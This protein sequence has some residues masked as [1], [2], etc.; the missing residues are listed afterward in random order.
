MKSVLWYIVFLLSVISQDL[1]SQIPRGGKPFPYYN[2]KSAQNKIFLPEFDL[3]QAIAE[4]L[5]ENAIEGKKPFPFAWNYSLDLTPANSGTWSEMPDGSTIWRI[6][7]VSSGAFGVNVDFSKFQLNPGCMVFIY[8]PSQ[9]Y[10]FG[11]FNSGNN[12][13]SANLPVS[14][15]KGEEIVVELQVQKDI[16]FGVL[17]IGSLAHAYIDIFSSLDTKLGPSGNCN[18]DINCPDGEDWQIIKKAICRITIKSGLNSVYCTGTLINNVKQDTVPYLLTANHCINS[19]TKANSALFLFDYEADTCDKTSETG[20]FSLAG[21]DLLATSDSLDFTLLRLYD[22]IP[23]IYKPYFAGWSLSQTPASSAVTIHHPEG[24]LKK[25]SIDN[26]PVTAEYQD[27]IPDNLKWLYTES[28][29]KAFWR[30]TKWESGTTEGGSSGAPLFNQ[31]KMIVG[32][33]T[34]GQANCTN[35]INDYFS[36]FHM[37]WD[38][39]SMPSKQLKYWLN[40]EDSLITSLQ[41]FNPYSSD[42]LIID[43]VEFADRYT[44]FPNPTNGLFTFETDSLDISGGLL[45]IYSLTGKKIFQYE[46]SGEKRIIADVSFLEQGLYIVEFSKGF[47]KVR[48]RLL[49][50]NP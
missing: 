19:N 4:S 9:E 22:S 49:I 50:T 14:F 35:P 44:L 48:K 41:G 36:K 20:S 2:L 43:P 37:C 28:V 6:H 39:Y 17:N 47:E 46:I 27:P 3:N 21:S 1:Y 10:F 5:S 30:V 38:Y 16:D 34:G 18:V 7:L 25:I 45:S 42:T 23:S 13:K 12:N 29:P 31:N 8:P 26:G 24:D 40:P 15:V 11:G 33:L 32:N